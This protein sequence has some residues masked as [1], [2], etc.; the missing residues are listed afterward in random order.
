MNKALFTITLLFLVFRLWDIGYDM[1]NSDAARWHRRSESF[2][3][4]IKKGDFASTYRHYQPGVSLMWVN[5]IVKQSISFYQNLGHGKNLTLENYQK[6]PLIDGV[7]KMTNIAIL[8]SV[9]IFQIY[10]LNKIFNK[11]V[12]LIYGILV[13]IEPFMIGID[14]WFHLTSFETY[15]GFTA[16]LLVLIYQKEKIHK[17]LIL[18]SLFLALSIL[19]KLTSLILLPLLVIILFTSNR[20]LKKTLIF[21]LLTF[22][23]IFLLFPALWVDFPNVIQKLFMAI[24]NAVSDDIRA[25]ELS[26]IVSYLFYPLILVYKLSPITLLLMAFSLFNIL[27]NYKTLDKNILNIIFYLATYLLLLSI[28]QKKIDRYVLVMI[29]PI[30][31]IIADYLSRINTKYLIVTFAIY[32]VFAAR[33]IYNYHPV[34][35][36]YYSPVFGGTRY[37]LSLG[38]YDNSGEYFAQAAFYL[39]KKGRDIS[40]H[41]PDNFESFSY[42]FGGNKQREFS[43]QTDYVVKSIDINRST[44]TDANCPIIENSFGPKDYKQIV[45]IYKCR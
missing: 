28:S 39:N 34:Y 24:T 31:V 18:G 11:K 25:T 27:K 33:L 40:V 17:W 30:L 10:L 32:A 12:A 21:I 22:L 6:F 45:Y 13:S 15:F 7:S 42:Y 3:S 37:A 23:F 9:L 38:I 5:S 8:F 41:I 19:S 16:F 35:S 4:V 14:R 1:S 36:A 29:P 44:A 20:D 26:G 43:P 2:L